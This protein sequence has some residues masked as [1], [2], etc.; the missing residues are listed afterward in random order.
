MKPQHEPVMVDRNRRVLSPARGGLFVDCTVG[1]GG[2]SRALLDAGADAPVGLDRDPDALAHRAR[3]PLAALC[4]RVELV[5]ADYREFD[6]VL[7]GAGHRRPLMA[8]SPISACRRCSS[9]PRTGIQFPARRA[10]DMRMDRTAGPTAADLMPLWTKR[11]LADVIF[12]FRRRAPSRRIARAIVALAERRRSRQPVSSRRSS[13]GR[14]RGAAISGSIRRRG[15]FRRCGSWSTASSTASTV[16]RLSCPPV[17]GRR[18]AGG[19]LVP[20]ARGSDREA[21]VPCARAGRGGAAGAHET[22]ARCRPTTKSRAIRGRAARSCGRLR[23]WH[24]RDGFRIRDQ[25]GRPQQPDRPRSGRS[26]PARSCGARRRLARSSSWS[27]CSRSGST[28]SCC[29]TATR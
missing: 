17:A 21:H 27:S 6:R 13:A 22:P 4:D 10:L 24:E 11:E 26:A 5:H 1:P 15:R 16:P 23:G 29:A 28:W 18:A 25:E 9:T 7:D 8:R 20:L 19:H 14:C 12:Q 3:A 2:H